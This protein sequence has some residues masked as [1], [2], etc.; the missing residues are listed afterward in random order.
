MKKK[1]ELNEIRIKRVFSE[2]VI[3]QYGLSKPELVKL[4]S[5]YL[6]ISHIARIK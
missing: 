2:R 6:E 5:L 1:N 3:L 4:S